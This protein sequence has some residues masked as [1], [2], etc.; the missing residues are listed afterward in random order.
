MNQFSRSESVFGTDGIDILK[1]ANVI[2]FGLGGVGSYCVEALVRSGIG[3]IA[4]VDNDDY[5]LT[6]LNRQLFALHSTLGQKKVDV[7]EKR[8]KDINPNCEVQ[9][10]EM[11][12]LPENSSFI[13]LSSYDYIVD[14]IDTVSAKILLAQKAQEF[15]VPI[16]SS[17]G[18]GNKLNPLDFEVCD[19]SKT[20]ICPLARVIRKELKARG[21][22]KLKCVYSKESP[23]TL[24]IPTNELK[25][26]N[27]A[28]GSVS[29]VPSVA[30]LVIASE[31]I[32]DLLQLNE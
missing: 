18:T 1:K 11:F 7:A 31:V 8:I 15:G 19:I 30:G 25:G 28:P 23:R 32:K 3:K 6:N 14:C 2:V 21:V 29:F 26:K 27:P 4:L 9:K 22:K 20:Q 10:F 5:S 17:M 12:Y 16:I 24:K 13:D